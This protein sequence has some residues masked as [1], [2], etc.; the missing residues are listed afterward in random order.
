MRI[1]LHLTL[2]IVILIAFSPAAGI[3]IHDS[4]CDVLSEKDNDKGDYN[5]A[6]DIISVTT[7]GS[8]II[9]E[10]YS[11]VSLSTCGTGDAYYYMVLLTAESMSN[12]W[13]AAMLVRHECDVLATTL[14]WMIGN[15]SYSSVDDWQEESSQTHF[16]TEDE[17]LIFMFPEYDAVAH[18]STTALSLLVDRDD[19]CTYSDF[20]P[21]Y[22]EGK[23]LLRFFPPF[24]EAEP[25]APLSDSVIVTYTSLTSTT[26]V[27]IQ[28]SNIPGFG[29]ATLA[30]GACAIT[31][32]R[33]SRKR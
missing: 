12:D 18:A 30:T 28:A 15:V 27:T 11:N 24:R 16:R 8:A 32:L 20:A 25:I 17:R 5:G 6:I 21:D 31:V 23:L 1:L 9:V 13:E 14:F 10:F 2:V 19:D 7:E 3:A 22:F 26:G 29:L 4:C 33:V